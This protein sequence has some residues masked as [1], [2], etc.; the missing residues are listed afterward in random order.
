MLPAILF[1]LETFLSLYFGFMSGLLA[2]SPPIPS[3][4]GP[5]IEIFAYVACHSTFIQDILASVVWILACQVLLALSK[6][7]FT[8]GRHI[9][10]ILR[11]STSAFLKARCVCITVNNNLFVLSIS[12]P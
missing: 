6:F 4:I 1:S 3:N 10:F 11:R 12:T 8:N 7:T 9:P 2:L 5:A